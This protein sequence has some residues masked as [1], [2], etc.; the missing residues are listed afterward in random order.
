MP[1]PS[2]LQNLVAPSLISAKF[3]KTPKSV[4]GELYTL[5]GMAR[6]AIL[7]R[8]DDDDIRTRFGIDHYYEIE[9]FIPLERKVPDL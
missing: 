9:V 4:G 6:R 5:R 1:N 2:N 7:I 3:I 8:V